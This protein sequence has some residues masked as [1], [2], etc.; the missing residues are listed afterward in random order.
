M[1]LTLPFIHNINISSNLRGLWTQTH[2]SHNPGTPQVFTKAEHL[3]SPRPL[4]SRSRLL[5]PSFS[6]GLSRSAPPTPAPTPAGGGPAAFRPQRGLLSCLSTSFLAPYL[7][8]SLLLSVVSLL[9]TPLPDTCLLFSNHSSLFPNWFLC[10][11]LIAHSYLIPHFPLGASTPTILW[12]P[13]PTLPT[14]PV[15]QHE[16]H[17]VCLHLS[18][19]ELL[20]GQGTMSYSF[21]SLRYDQI[22]TF[23]VS[24][25]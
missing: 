19:Q 8:R 22:N 18:S 7:Q 20:W 21:L 9:L 5:S 13:T 10:P 17:S 14:A 3:S 2:R 25:H 24:K 6:L 15:C 23:R 11:T 4:E 1:L 12:A 16:L